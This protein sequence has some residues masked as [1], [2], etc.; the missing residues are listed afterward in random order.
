MLMKKEYNLK[1][2]YWNIGII[3]F[4]YLFNY[5]P[6]GDS[7]NYNDIKNFNVNKFI[8]QHGN[9]EKK[10]SVYVKKMKDIILTCLNLNVNE[11]GC[12]LNYIINE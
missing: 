10:Y 4:Y 5:F 3:T 9:G 11:R 6:F 12:K 7:K 8:N 2:E 1:I